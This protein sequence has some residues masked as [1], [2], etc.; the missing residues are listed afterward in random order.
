MGLPKSMMIKYQERGYGASDKIV[1]H[2][3]VGDYYLKK[4]I[5]DNGSK[6][7]CDYCGKSRKCIDLEDLM[8]PIMDGIWSE[9]EDATGCMG[10]DSSEGGFIGATT[11]DSYDLIYDELW[12]ELKIDNESLLDDIA[13]LIIYQHRL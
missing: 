5:K 8:E 4:Y 2:E 7:R 3:C 6:D 12:E 10:W 11:W 13:T 9:Y 1:C